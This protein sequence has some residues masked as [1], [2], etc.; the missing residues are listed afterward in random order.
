MTLTK[1][2]KQETSLMSKLEF[3]TL[4]KIHLSTIFYDFENMKNTK[5]IP[6]KTKSFC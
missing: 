2:K 4:K 6:L 1:A 5:I 3:L